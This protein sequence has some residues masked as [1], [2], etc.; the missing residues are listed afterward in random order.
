M[1]VLVLS[2]VPSRDWD[3]DAQICAELK[4]LGHI[5]IL[6]KYLQDGRD[7]V[8]IER[9]DLVLVP[10]VRC[11]YT[12]DFATRCKQW[13]MKVVARRSEAGVSH[14]MYEK[15]DRD[16]RINQIGRYDYNDCIDME[17]VWGREFAEI[18]VA[19]E[20]VEGSKVR[21][22]GG[23]SLDRY[24]DR[25]A[26]RLKTLVGT[27]KAFFEQTGFDPKKKTLL[28]ACGF[29]FADI[30]PDY[31]LP[32]AMPGDPIHRK[33]YDRDMDSRQ[34]WLRAMKQ[35]WPRYKDRFNFLVRPHPGEIHAQYASQLPLEMRI[36]TNASVA[37]AIY[38]CDVLIHAGSTLAVDAHVLG[39]P[40]LSFYGCADDD[41]I[42]NVSP[43][44]STVT[45]LSRLLDSLILGRSNASID[46]LHDL[47]PFYGPIDGKA[48]KRVARAVHEFSSTQF[49][50]HIPKRWP[51]QELNDYS[52]PGV[53]KLRKLPIRYCQTC[54]K[55]FQVLDGQ[56]RIACPHCGISTTVNK[57]AAIG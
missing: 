48:C 19:E 25:Y 14:A 11:P 30:N 45:G 29:K 31:N 50:L 13:G 46:S 35:L 4:A 2:M 34:H 37:Q 36:D 38:F 15:L 8:V 43:R 7:A 28:W 33:L 12:R 23:I 18:L 20:K 52:T 42:G 56:N 5:P 49:D 39:K 53:I 24:L 55:P 1:R 44:C 27:R 32:E 54:G 9:P 3:I 10:P 57:L 21:I 51:E 17:L 40:A 47:E 16:A 26:E 41:L 6:R 22:I